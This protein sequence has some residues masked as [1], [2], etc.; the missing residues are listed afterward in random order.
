ML[1]MD[2]GVVTE[3]RDDFNLECGGR[4]RFGI[5]RSHLENETTKAAKTAALQMKKSPRRAT[6]AIPN[7]TR[8]HERARL[9]CLPRQRLDFVRKIADDTREGGRPCPTRYETDPAG[10]THEED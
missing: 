7:P 2:E 1:L 6:S 3:G 10:H 9:H 4:R 8:I 5:F